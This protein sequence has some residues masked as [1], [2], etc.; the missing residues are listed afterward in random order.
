[1][2]NEILCRAWFELSLDSI[3][4]QT[5]E[6]RIDTPEYTRNSLEFALK[7]TSLS[8]ELQAPSE[9]QSREGTYN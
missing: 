6:Q 1:M 8:R 4:G 3:A 9:T 7:E 2:E 5:K